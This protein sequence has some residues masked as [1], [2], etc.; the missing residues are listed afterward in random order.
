ML[1]L[2]TAFSGCSDNAIVKIFDKDIS[3]NKIPC[4]R[5]IVFP[6]DKVLEQTLK[7]LYKF[8]PDCDYRLE[9]SKKG[10]I[11]CNSNQ[12]AAKKTLS[13]F[14]SSYLRMDVSK[15]SKPVYSYYVDLKENVSSEDVKS[16]FYRLQKDILK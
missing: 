7:K 16:G 1:L 4:I 2:L 12:N 15:N 13:T 8:S 5:L 9:V 11:V 10:G 6:P 3:K 14:P